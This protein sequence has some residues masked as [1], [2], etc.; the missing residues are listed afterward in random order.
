MIKHIKRIV[1]EV[2][3][4][5]VCD[6]CYTEVANAPHNVCSVCGRVACRSCATEKDP[7]VCDACSKQYT[8]VDGQV[9]NRHGNMT[10]PLFT[11]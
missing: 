11:S 3:D 5:L 2:R 6:F 1:V 10:L 8:V 4:A 7:F 9:V